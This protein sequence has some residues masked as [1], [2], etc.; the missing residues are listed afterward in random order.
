[1]SANKNRA[2][3]IYDKFRRWPFGQRL[4]SIYG[5]RQAPYFKTVS[6]LVTLLEPNQCNILIKKRKRVENH[7]GTMHIIAIANGLEMAM[8]FMA[9]ASIPKHLRWIPKGMELSY[10][11]KGETD[12][13]CKATVPADGWVPGDLPVTVEA[14]DT[15]GTPVVVGTIMLW[16][17][18]KPAR[19]EKTKTQG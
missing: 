10:P 14:V 18:E 6:P 7:I 13:L 4:F 1:M 12:I 11:N 8:G 15:S 2:L 16:I 9:E 5:A 3:V 17:S 19:T